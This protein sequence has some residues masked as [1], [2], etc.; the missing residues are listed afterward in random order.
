MSDGLK[1]ETEVCMLDTEEYEDD[2]VGSRPIPEDTSLLIVEID[3]GL[4]LMTSILRTN[5]TGIYT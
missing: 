1:V 3:H 4:Y 2:A 5:S